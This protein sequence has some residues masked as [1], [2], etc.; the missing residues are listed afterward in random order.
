M[1]IIFV[2][3]LPKGRSSI[4]KC[5]QNQKSFSLLYGYYNPGHFL[6]GNCVFQNIHFVLENCNKIMPF[7]FDFDACLMHFYFDFFSCLVNPPLGFCPGATQVSMCTNARPQ[8][9][10]KGIFSFL[11]KRTRGHS[12]MSLDIKCLSIDPFLRQSYTQWPPYVLS[13]HPMTPFSTFVPNLTY[14]RK[15]FDTLRAYFE[16]FNGYFY[17]KFANFGL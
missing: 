9:L 3:I 5:R 2:L 15:K 10:K 12:Y 4:S 6:L 8:K 17:I 1:L 11:I 7:H 16:K 14:Q 13:P